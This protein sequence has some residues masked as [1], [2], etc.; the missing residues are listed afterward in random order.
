MLEVGPV[1]TRPSMR[2]TKGLSRR[3]PQINAMRLPAVFPTTDMPVESQ[4]GKM[5]PDA[6]SIGVVGK[7]SAVQTDK[8]PRYATLPA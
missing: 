6:S 4:N 2:T 7:Q 3:R 1:P 5:N 8:P